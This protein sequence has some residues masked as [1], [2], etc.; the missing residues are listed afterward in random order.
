M[1]AIERIH[2]CIESAMQSRPNLFIVASHVSNGLDINLIIDGDEL[3]NISDCIEL[4]R[5]IE[6]NLDREEMD[7]S[8]K[9]QSPG[10]D[11]P[12]LFPRQYKKHVGRTLKLKT[13][14]GKLEGKLAEVNDEGIL[15]VWKS[16]EKKPVGKGK[17]TVIH[18][19]VISFNAIEQAKI[20]LT[21]NTK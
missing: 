5:A 21:F 15:L 3:I 13:A 9:V 18:E 14:E 11:E 4:S 2:K 1:Q 12:L 17:R 8:I 20:K 19:K 10:A 16:R 6:H 7:F